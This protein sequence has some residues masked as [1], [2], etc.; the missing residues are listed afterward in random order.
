LTADAIPAIIMTAAAAAEEKKREEAAMDPDDLKRIQL[1]E[2][3]LY[4][5]FAKLFKMKVPLATVMNQVKAD[6]KL[7]VNDVLLLAPKD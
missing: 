1:Q 6:P 5:R 2:N 4:Q 3:P 7:N